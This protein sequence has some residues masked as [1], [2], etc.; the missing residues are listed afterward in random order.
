MVQ[1]FVPGWDSQITINAEDLTIVGNVLGFVRSRASQPKPVFGSKSQREIPGQGS[2][3]INV[4]GHI[5]VEKVAAL[6]AI[7]E[8]N[9]SVA[10]TIVA[11]NATDSTE[12][13]QWAGN[14]AVTELSVD[15]DAT[16]E[17]DF[18]LSGTMD[19]WPTYTAPTP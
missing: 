16:G 11:G 1:T 15:A 19:E 7:I 3:T 14:M 12:A 18:T 17:W 13:G 10:Y 4:G 8:A 9:A 2:G 6:E 5:S